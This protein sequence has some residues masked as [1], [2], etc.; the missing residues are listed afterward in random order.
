MGFLK[1]TVCHHRHV[2]SLWGFYL[3]AIIAKLL[4]PKYRFKLP[5]LDLLSD[6][7]FT[8]YLV[9]FKEHRQF[10]T[11]RRWNLYQ[12]LRLV[13]DIPGDTAE[14]G[15][16]QGSSSYLICKF[17]S[18]SRKFTRYHY[19][20]D[21]FEGLSEPEQ[22]DGNYWLRGDFSTSPIIAK[23]NLSCFKNAVFL[24]GWVPERF[25]EVRDKRFSFVHL[26]L[27]LYKPTLDSIAFFYPLLEKG[28][29]ILCDDYGFS[30]CPGAT[31]A[32]DEFL[33]DKPEKM[34]SLS[35]GGGFMIKGNLT[36]STVPL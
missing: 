18:Q 10:N 31:K 27:D 21:S 13:E 24:K 20:F 5:L 22:E 14:C 26:D 29:I 8:N 15:V 23:N 17:N 6:E 3:L 1:K 30:T 35:C 25:N 36:A 2:V 11:D 19:M 12:L 4:C 9:Y 32:I 34:V 28:G 33:S 7:A 16:Y